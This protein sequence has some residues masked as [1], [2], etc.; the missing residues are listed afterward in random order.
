M[1]RNSDDT[2]QR[3]LDAA[4]QEL[5]DQGFVGFGINAIARRAGCDKKLIYRYFDGLDGLVEAM[6]RSAATRLEEALSPHLDPPPASYAA[7]MER[8]ALA[9]FDHLASDPLYRQI[10]L[11]EATAPPA[12]TEGF[13]AARG[14]ALQHWL[15]SARRAL[16]PP[17]G[18]DAATANA[19][20]IA[21]IEGVTVL[22]PAGLDPA[23]PAT[24]VRLRRALADLVRAAYRDRPH[25]TP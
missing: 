7:L 22:S 12:L 15:A 23:D 24:R 3:L 14:Q 18:L 11:M 20:L 5:L 17:A 19:L 13:R 4:L 16:A 8:L 10:R 21:A 2:R 9:L 6:G 1:S 25:H